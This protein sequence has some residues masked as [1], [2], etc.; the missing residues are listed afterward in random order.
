MKI[1]I[2]IPVY[3]VELYLDRC[4]QSVVSQS[5]KDTEILL[6]ND[7]S[8]DGSGKICLEWKKRDKRIKYV[9]TPNCGLGKARNLGI[10]L[11]RA[12]YLTFIDSDDWVDQNFIERIMDRMLRDQ[13]DI[14][15]CDI[16]YVDELTGE[17]NVSKIRLEKEVLSLEEDTSAINKIRV[18][19]WGKIYRK[20]LFTETGIYFPPIVFEDFPTIPVI[21]A[22]AQRI[23]YIPMAYYNY[24]RNRAGS[25]SSQ[26]ENVGDFLRA[27]EVLGERFQEYSLDK[28]Y[29]EMKK[30][31]IGQVRFAHRKW[32][33]SLN[34][35][36]GKILWKMRE[37]MGD[38]IPELKYFDK[39]RFF[40]DGSR[41]LK[42]ALEK[43]II[44]KEQL[45]DD[46]K[47]ADY[48]V[49]FENGRGIISSGTKRLMI[50]GQFEKEKDYEKASWNI[51]EYMMEKI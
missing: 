30:I 47:D 4:L 26:E 25:L 19:A 9:Q 1:S 34:R 18:F 40:A 33:K 50:P 3:N 5:Y 39:R 37:Y 21:A 43:I 22:L 49:F 51:A 29:T 14:G 32:G 13:S 8:T 15:L 24:C 28:C 10:E 44:Y 16:N 35:D 48:Y 42:D 11:S 36:T 20:K 2:I 17:V 7:G 46:I 27:L 12:E 41:L 6:I 31:F 23:S 38:K 45:T